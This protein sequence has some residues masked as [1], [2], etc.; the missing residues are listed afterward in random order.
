MTG[1]SRF[2]AQGMKLGFIG[3][4]QMGRPSPITFSRGAELIVGSRSDSASGEFG[5]KGA[6]RDDRIRPG[7][8]RPA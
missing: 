3:L 4:G 7:W 2:R 1:E 8:P 6:K 5:D